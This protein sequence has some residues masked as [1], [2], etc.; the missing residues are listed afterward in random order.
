MFF[1]PLLSF[2]PSRL[3]LIFAGKTFVAAMLALFVSFEL[4]LVNPMWSIGTVLIIANPYSGMVSSK[5]VYRLIGTVAGAVI[6]VLM[7]PYL[8]N[9]PWLFTCV[10]ALWVG[11]SLYV[12][13]LDR[14][15]RSYVFMLAGYSTVL[16]VFNAISSIETYSIFDMALAR[17]LEISVGVI[18]SAVVSASFFP[19]HLGAVIRQRVNKA[20][21][22]LEDIF[23][24]ILNHHD[25]SQDYA[26]IL[27]VMTRDT[28]DI[29]TLAVHL[30]YEKGELKGMTKPLQEMLHQM[31]LVVANL[32]ALSQRI[33]QLQQIPQQDVIVQLQQIQQSVLQFLKQN[34]KL[35]EDDLQQRPA[36]FD[37]DFDCLM[38]L[39]TLEQQTIV[40]ALKM[41]IR[42]FIAN[43]L[44]VKLIW[45]Y[46]QQG[47]KDIPSSITTL[48]TNYPS[49]HRD[50][51]VAVR[52]G[53]SAA[54]ITLIVTAAW[55]LSGWKMGFMM[56]QMGV[57]TA[58][59]LTAIDNPVPVLRIFIVW[60]VISAGLA[61]VYAFG[62]FPHV[63]D[64]WQ[65]ALV[66]CP[67]VLIAVSMMANPMLMPVGMVL[68]INTM[69]GLNLNNRYSMDAVVYLD[70]SIA[71][72]LGVTTSLI[73][74]DLVRAMSPDTSASRILALHYQALRKSIYLNYGTDFKVHLRSM[75][76][77][78]GILNTKAVQSPS[79]KVAIQHALIESSAIVD[80]VRLQE[81]I[82][83][84]PEGDPLKSQ[85]GLLQQN[86]DEYFRIQEK[87][88]AQMD[89]FGVELQQQ[90]NSILI[91][92][93]QLEDI[94][95]KQRLLI[96][97]NN[98]YSSIG[99]VSLTEQMVVE[100]EYSHG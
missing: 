1:K 23:E 78:V 88:L 21:N 90:I 18:A 70:S 19:V 57:I 14:T 58:C 27:S 7:M 73:V 77:R 75:L 3:D 45:Q 20:L 76:D 37:Q 30:A 42:H 66:L 80:L 36:E 100:G 56:A 50:Y 9:T 97:L 87:H 8:L 74:I 62:I 84:L 39:V 40:A 71:M 68:G 49:L 65:L 22:D 79:I 64:F 96:S 95:F 38:T 81:L 63:T 15:P 98:I 2:R 83:L 72:I 4:N 5:C 29:H 93:K 82:E 54:L 47:K 46:I 92:V 60:S 55:I 89:H 25:N 99:H 34:Q 48:T 13:L 10:L 85:L 33:T 51:G 12:S 43:I 86:L 61:F 41:D 53:V 52:G 24:N 11:F 16:I 94:Q 6:A 67:L 35:T 31:S 26:Q 91:Q 44:A 32:V 69:M 28:A 59:I 17:V